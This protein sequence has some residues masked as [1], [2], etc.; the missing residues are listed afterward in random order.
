MI[1]FNTLLVSIYIY[2]YMQYVND[3]SS[4]YD[5]TLAIADRCL[6]SSVPVSAQLPL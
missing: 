6:D 5:A 4:L 3:I 2:T 1:Y